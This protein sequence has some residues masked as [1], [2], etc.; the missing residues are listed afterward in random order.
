MA[1]FNTKLNCTNHSKAFVTFLSNSAGIA[2]LYDYG[3][4]G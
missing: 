3:Y 2:K 1:N 4:E